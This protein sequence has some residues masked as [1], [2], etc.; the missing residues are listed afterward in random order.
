[1]S[2]LVI[3]EQRGGKWNRLSFEALA[4]GGKIA[5]ALGEK[6]EA[7]VIGSGIE[8]LANEA[9]AYE[10]ANVI[11]IEDSSLGDYTPEAYT[12]A[13]AQ[14]IEAKKPKVVLFPHTYQVRDYSPKLAT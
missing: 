1:M 3:L 4:A 8:A 5:N 13:L 11:R 14:L 9:A 2:V 7:V 12:D 6:V 10:I